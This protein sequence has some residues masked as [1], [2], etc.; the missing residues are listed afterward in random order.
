MTVWLNGA[1]LP[2]QEA[3]IDPADRG[4][5]LGD[6]IFETL[7]VEA[8]R[9]AHRDRHL[10]RLRGGA[11]FFGI[12]C[13]EAAVLGEALEA[14]RAAHGLRE[15]AL[16]LTLTR[17]P[18]PR[19]VLP[20]SAPAPSV[21]ITAASGLPSA[22]GGLRL[23][24]ARS[25]RRNAFSPTA[26]F[27][28]LNYLDGIV[29]RREAQQG[30][31]D[32]ALLRNTEGR[33][34]EA[35]AA[36]LLWRDGDGAWF[37]PPVGDGALPGIRR[38]VLIEGGAVAERGLDDPRAITA[39]ILCSSLAM[40]PVVAIDDRPLAPDTAALARLRREAADQS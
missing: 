31:F 26:R 21:L 34:A 19:G 8:G 14:L 38:A 6:G 29:A 9:I 2:A 3:R 24:I 40:L 36:N 35:T 30:G 22:P 1:L 5:L 23:C 28:T 7:A 17:G 39:A 27:K 33:I 25:T 16:R 18:A 37:T 10:E 32:D 4:L 12:P 11:A 13:P 20:P 15:G